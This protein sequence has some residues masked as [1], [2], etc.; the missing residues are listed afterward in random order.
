MDI[1]YTSGA[2]C[3]FLSKIVVRQAK[4]IEILG[5][6]ISFVNMRLLGVPQYMFTS[7]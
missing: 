3:P 2:L 1:S 5:Y 7:I 6:T 4:V